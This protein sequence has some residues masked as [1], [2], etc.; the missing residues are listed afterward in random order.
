MY[1]KLIKCFSN[2]I[3]IHKIPNIINEEDIDKVIEEIVNSK[4]FQKSDTEIEIY[5]SIE[6]LNFPQEDP[7]GI[8]ILDALNEKEMNDSRVHAM[9]KRSRN[10]SLSIVIISHDYCEL[11]KRTIR[12]NEYIYHIFKPKKFRDVEN[13]YQDKANM[14]MS[15][16]VYKYLI[17]TCWD[18]TMSTSYN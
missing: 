5:D 13:L 2:Y 17:I 9:F 11:S 12:A 15:P 7:G 1:Q 14:E 4:D 18:G 10:N 16:N 8:I 3:P 6:E